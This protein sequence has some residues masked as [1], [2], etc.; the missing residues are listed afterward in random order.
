MM[1]G[2]LTNRSSQSDG[3]APTHHVVGVHTFP[4]PTGLVEVYD[5]TAR[6]AETLPAET[7]VT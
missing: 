6:A 7:S 1:T 4:E 2:W 3:F 5:P